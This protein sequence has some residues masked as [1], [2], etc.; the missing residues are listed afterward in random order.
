MSPLLTAVELGKLAA[1]KACVDNEVRSEMRIGVG[2]G[3]TVKFLIECLHE[4]CSSGKLTNIQCVP[5]SYQVTIN[6]SF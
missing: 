1:A 5:T 2:S 6:F 3:S 4:A